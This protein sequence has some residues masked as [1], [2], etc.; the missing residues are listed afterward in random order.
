MINTDLVMEMWW[1]VIMLWSHGIV[2]VMLYVWPQVI[3]CVAEAAEGV[4]ET[5]CGE[6][7]VI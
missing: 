7:G 2:F 4:A 3:Y 6:Y 1:C 5:Y